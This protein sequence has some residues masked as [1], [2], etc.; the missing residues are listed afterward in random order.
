ML[1]FFS[2]N[3]SDLLILLDDFSGHLKSIYELETFYGDETLH[4]LLRHSKEIIES[5]E[6]FEEIISLSEED[7]FEGDEMDEEGEEG[8]ESE[9][10]SDRTAEKTDTE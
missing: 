8:E 6:E 3:L 4:S 5:I 2:E 9:F 7:E 10:E 1:M